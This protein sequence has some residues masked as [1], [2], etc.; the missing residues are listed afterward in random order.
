MTALVST[1]TGS[2]SICLVTLRYVKGNTES[3][4][5]RRL[6]FD[7]LK[8]LLVTEYGAPVTTDMKE[9]TREALWTFRSGSIS[10]DQL[11]VPVLNSG[12]LT[13]QYRQHDKANQD[14]L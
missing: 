4:T 9:E 3:I 7:T 11:E 5:N 6:A 8:D 14:K 2:G 13:I 12:F 1:R 10:L